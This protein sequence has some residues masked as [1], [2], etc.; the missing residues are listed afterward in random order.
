[1]TSE[2]LLSYYFFLLWLFHGA[3]NLIIVS[4]EIN[5]SINIHMSVAGGHGFLIMLLILG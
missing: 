2:S 3:I 1:M 4:D 5:Q